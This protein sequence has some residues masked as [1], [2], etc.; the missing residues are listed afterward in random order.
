MSGATAAGRR[1]P[2]ID[3]GSA[4]SLARPLAFDGGD[5]LHFGAPAPRRRALQL[6]GFS[7]EVARGASCNCATLELTPHCNGTH[8]ES[9]AHLVLEPL[10]ACEV[11]PLEPLPALLLSLAPC[12]AGDTDEDSDPVPRPGDRLLTRGALRAAWPAHMPF[13]PR[14]LVLRTGPPTFSAAPVRG[15]T[16]PAVPQPSPE[17]AVPPYLSRQLVT[18]LVERGVEHLVV[19]LPSIDRSHDEGRLCGHR[20][21]FGLP[22]GSVRL[23]EARRAGCTI[24]EFAQVPVQLADGPCALQLTT[25]R[26]AGD[27]VPSRPLLYRLEAA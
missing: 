3:L 6:P 10:D 7:G 5:P 14:A 22:P 8:T 4:V 25:P 26:I 21:F 2:R 1:P 19:E 20:L 17:D 9:V 16:L 11:A 13:E 24:T 23:A 27:A 15:P 18:E 12:S